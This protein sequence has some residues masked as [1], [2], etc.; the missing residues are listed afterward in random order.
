VVVVVVAAAVVVDG[1]VAAAAAVAV[2]GFVAAV[3]V[4]VGSWPSWPPP[5]FEALRCSASAQSRPEE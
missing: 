2:D 3:E 1:F 4:E 5:L